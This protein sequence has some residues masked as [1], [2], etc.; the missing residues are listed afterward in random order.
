MSVPIRHPD[1]TNRYI[2]FITSKSEDNHIKLEACMRNKYN[3]IRMSKGKVVDYIGITFE[4][5][6]PGS[7]IYNSSQFRALHPTRMRG[8]AVEAHAGCLHPL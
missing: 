2:L 7:N 3:E 1:I 8:V 5:I 6:V 4:Y